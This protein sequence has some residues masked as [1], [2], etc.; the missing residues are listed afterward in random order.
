MG[1]VVV[2][3]SNGKLGGT[4]QTNDGIVGMV[5]TGGIDGTGDYALGDPILITSLKGLEDAGITDDGNE[6]AVRQVTDFYK[7]AG[8]KVQ[9]YLMLVP[10]TVTLS[11]ICDNTYADGGKKLLDYAEGKIKVFGAMTDD[12][13]MDAP[14]IAGGLNSEV[15]EALV[16]MKVM[17]EAYR[18]AQLPFR[19]V[20]GGTSYAGVPADLTDLTTGTSNNR[21]MVMIGDTVAGDEESG[22]NACCL[23]LLMGLI[24]LIPVQRKISRVK[25]GALPI[26]AAYVGHQTVKEVGAGDMKVIADRGYVTFKTYANVAGYFFSSDPMNTATTDDYCMLARGRVIDKAHILAYTTFVQE[27]DEEVLIVAGKLSGAHCAWLEQQIENQINSTMTAKGEISEVTCF[28]DPEQNIL[29]TSELEVELEI[30]P[31]GYSS[32]IIINLGM[33]NPALES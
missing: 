16:N 2:N 31:V 12:A 33:A 7:I 20:L 9:L 4:I 25:N 23:G 21:V 28:V 14:V 8:A 6:F 13:A 11:M 1:E 29:S 32:N 24:A 10:N 27:V 30:V 3:I 22:I 26:T 19:A 5:L 15:A 17:A 18:L